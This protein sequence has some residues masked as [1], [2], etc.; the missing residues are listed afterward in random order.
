VLIDEET[1]ESIGDP[2][3]VDCIARRLFV[4]KEAIGGKPGGAKAATGIIQ[5]N[6]EAAYLHTDAHKAALRL[7]LLSLT[8]RLKP[9]DEP[10][11][12]INGAIERS[13]AQIEPTRKG[14]RGRRGASE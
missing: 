6:I 7:Y 14:R 2:V 4:L 3:T 10:V 5:S 8:G 13:M 11:Q 12:L 9:Q 1:W